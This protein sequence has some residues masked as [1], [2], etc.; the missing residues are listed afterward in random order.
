MRVSHY[1]DDKLQTPSNKQGQI[2]QNGH[3]K[4]WEKRQERLHVFKNPSLL[5]PL[6]Y[7]EMTLFR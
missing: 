1:D 7:V 6:G 3:T 4:M 5:S 2:L